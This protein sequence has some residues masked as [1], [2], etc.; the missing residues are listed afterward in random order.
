MNRDADLSKKT[1]FE[2]IPRSGSIFSAINRGVSS[3][4]NQTKL[5]RIWHWYYAHLT[6]RWGSVDEAAEKKTLHFLKQ[7]PE[8][9]FVVFPGID[10]YSH[11]S[12][13]FHPKT[14]EAYERLDRAVGKMVQSLKSRGQWEE[15]IFLIV[16]DHGLS[17]TQN[18]FPLNQFLENMGIKTFYYPKIVFKWNFDAASMVSG[19]GMANV[20]FKSES[21]W[22]G[23]TSWEELSSRKDK[24]IEKIL[25]NEEIGLLAG[26]KKDGSLVVKSRRGEAVIKTDQGGVHYRLMGGDPFGYPKLPE[27]MTDRQS[28]D[29]TFNTDYPDGPAQMLQVFRSKRAGDL[30][31]SA[32]KGSDLRLRHEVPE[33]KSSHGS[34]RWEHMN[35]PLVSNVPFAKGPIRSVDV[36]PKVLELLGR[37]IPKNIDGQIPSQN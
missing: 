13:P 27:I 2:I 7:D 6:D 24:V 20:Y 3:W 37:P 16:S 17:E 4:G 35:I 25:E 23:R 33:H 34:F 11:L 18:H 26:Q 12:S 22:K 30:I 36:F 14:Y 15:T 31:L 8:F 1:L 19:N 32:E 10:E 9:V 29:L 21:G 28:L 5:S